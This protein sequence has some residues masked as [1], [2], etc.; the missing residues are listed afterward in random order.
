MFVEMTFVV[1]PDSFTSIM[2]R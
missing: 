1:F 2:V